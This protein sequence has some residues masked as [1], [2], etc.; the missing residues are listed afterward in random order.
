[1]YPSAVERLLVDSH[2]S[3][4]SVEEDVDKYFGDDCMSDKHD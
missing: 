2:E 1:M 4:E 3:E